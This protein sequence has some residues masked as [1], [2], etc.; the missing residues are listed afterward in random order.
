MKDFLVFDGISK[1]FG[2]HRVLDNVSLS[3]SRGE[4]FSFLGPS[5][6][7]KTTLLRICAG[8]EVPDSGRVILNGT[9]ITALR[10]NRRQVNTVFQNYALFPNLTVYENIAFG[11]RVAGVKDPDLRK[12][13]EVY[14]ELIQLSDHASKKPDKLRRGTETACGHC[15]RSDKQ[16]QGPSSGRTSGRP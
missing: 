14:L 7:G 9:D 10:P 5:G 15:P 2:N 4:I 16:A 3:V 6:C 11:L 1:S 8:F 13:V 12:K